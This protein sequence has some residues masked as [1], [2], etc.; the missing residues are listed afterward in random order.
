M[1]FV[2]Q[3]P[4]PVALSEI[5]GRMKLP[6][7]TAFNIVRTLTKRG[8]LEWVDDKGYR[9]GPLV[10]E[11]AQ[12]RSSSMDLIAR[13]RPFLEDVAARTGET[14]FLSVP[15]GDE[16]VF[17]DKVEST[18]AI[19]YSIQLGTRRPLYCSAHGKVVL[20]SLD[21]EAFDAY[22]MRTKLKPITDKTIVERAKLERAVARIRQLGYA[23]SD[24]EFIDNVYS[25]SAPLRAAA[26]G[27]PLGMISAVGPTSRVK[28]RRQHVVAVLQ[29]CVASANRE[30]A[31]LVG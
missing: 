28:P 16:I 20:A 6:R 2:S 18:Q 7:T 25:I 9:L 12:R 31:D 3:A 8:A 19:R 13:V 24:G 4:E 27:L 14:C 21:D 23:V 29:D 15:S 17:V 22:V 1:M 10:V 26:N 11:L 30:C 5:T